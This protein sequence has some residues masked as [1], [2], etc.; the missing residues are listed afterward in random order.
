MEEQG[1]CEYH[2]SNFVYMSFTNVR[3]GNK[4]GIY[5]S[6]RKK[7]LNYSAISI[8]EVPDNFHIDN[9]AGADFNLIA[10]NPL[11]THKCSQYPQL[12]TVSDPLL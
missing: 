5:K 2:F 4:C 1:Y 8:P 11:V 9:E 10:P 7:K 6:C 3:A 12:T